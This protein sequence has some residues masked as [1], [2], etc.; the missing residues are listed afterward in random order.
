MLARVSCSALAALALVAAAR[1]AAPQERPDPDRMVTR[2]YAVADLVIPV[3]NYATLKIAGKPAAEVRKEGTTLEEK[4]IRLIQ[5]SIRPTTWSDADGQ[6]TIQYFPLGMSLV[7]TQSA[8][9]QEEIAELLESL[10]RL[11][12]L[13]VA[14][15]THVVTVPPGVLKKICGEFQKVQGQRFG[16]KFLSDAER[17]KF[18]EAVQSDRRSEITQAPKLTLFN[19][20][21][22]EVNVTGWHK[23]ATELEIK[24]VGEKLVASVVREDVPAGLKIG[25]EPVVSADRK[26]VHLLVNAN[27]TEMNKPSEVVHAFQRPTLTTMGVKVSACIPDGRTMVVCGWDSE[28]QHQTMCHVLLV[29]PRVIIN[30]DAEEKK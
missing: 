18:L 19:G 13:E 12:D 3:T 17:K 30:A 27:I 4:L 5:T 26:Y 7:V 11:Q 1:A 9:I 14:V 21:N 22:T 6:G 2:T 20:Q 10:R 25:L 28:R 16:L 23:L 29:T 24:Q 8:R 15:E